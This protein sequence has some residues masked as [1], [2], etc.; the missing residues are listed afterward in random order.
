[1]TYDP[2]P[3]S[4][5]NPV[6]THASIVAG[7]LTAATI[8]ADEHS[9]I[10]LHSKNPFDGDIPDID[11]SI[12]GGL[13]IGTDIAT[14]AHVYDFTQVDVTDGSGAITFSDRSA[15]VYTLTLDAS[16]SGYEYLRLD[17]EE[18]TFGVINLAPGT[19]ES[20]KLVL[21]DKA[22][23]SALVSAKNGADNSPIAGASVRLFN[24]TLG[25]DTTITADI[26]GQSYFPTSNTP[27]VAG[28]Y[29]IEV[30][31]SGFTTATDTV[32]LAGTALTK[33]TVTLS[34]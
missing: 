8:V 29:D 14:S 7:S 31:A 16:E 20:V 17:P 18:T 2:Y 1:M 21:A 34:P 10:E 25:Y 22:L 32:V 33:K 4:A 23:S 12:T 27:L 24:T 19:T 5:F 26:Y 9:D 28:T 3:A 13:V 30:S 11:F 6:N 15:G